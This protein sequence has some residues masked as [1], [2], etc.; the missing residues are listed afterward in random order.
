MKSWTDGLVVPRGNPEYV[1]GIRPTLHPKLFAR[2]EVLSVVMLI[3]TKNDLLKLTCNPVESEKVLNRH[4]NL[5]K[6]L[7][8]TGRMRSVSSAY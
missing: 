7:A 1:K 5:N 2:C 6:V 3:G 4:F 8:S